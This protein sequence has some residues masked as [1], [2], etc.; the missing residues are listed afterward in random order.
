VDKTIYIVLDKTSKPERSVCGTYATEGLA[1]ASVY[2]AVHEKTYGDK[3][4]SDFIVVEELL[5]E[6]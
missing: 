2:D 4:I 5:F 6:K 3:T 1:K